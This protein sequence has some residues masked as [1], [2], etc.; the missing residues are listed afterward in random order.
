MDTIVTDSIAILKTGSP[1]AYTPPDD[2]GSAPG[3]LDFVQAMADAQ[4][5]EHEDMKRWI[6]R[7][8]WDPTAF[9][10]DHVNS[11]LAEIKI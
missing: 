10:I 9:D 4:H 3:Y 1:D 6:G 11:W 5:P 7:D 8:S 2:C